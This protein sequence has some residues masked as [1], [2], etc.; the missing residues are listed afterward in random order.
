MRK[1][2]L[3]LEGGVTKTVTAKSPMAAKYKYYNSAHHFKTE[4]FVSR[5]E[6]YNKKK[7]VGRPSRHTGF[8]L[9]MP[10]LPF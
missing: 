10:R 5:V 6:R 9:R 7:K 3:H 2:K 8:G 4:K 1:Y